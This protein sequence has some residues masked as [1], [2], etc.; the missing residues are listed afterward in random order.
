MV[1]LPNTALAKG[2]DPALGR[3]MQRV[4]NRFVSA[5]RRTKPLKGFMSK[6]VTV[7]FHTDDRS[8]GTFDGKTVVDAAAIDGTVDVPGKT[9]GYAWAIEKKIKPAPKT[10]KLHVGKM[11]YEILRT[12]REQRLER[13]N[14]ISVDKKKLT[15]Y[16]EG[17][18]KTMTFHF[19]LEGKRLLVHK[20]GF[21]ESDPG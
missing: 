6:R 5:I 14:R 9:G 2:A 19:R 10:L 7:T 17:I 8:E 13:R 20:L 16:I 1:S 18:T 11:A 21:S 12:V 4:A 3:Q 15:F